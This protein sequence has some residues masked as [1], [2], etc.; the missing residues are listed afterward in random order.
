MRRDDRVRLGVRV[1]VLLTPGTA[2][3]TGP[4]LTELGTTPPPPPITPRIQPP[5]RQMLELS[6]VEALQSRIYTFPFWPHH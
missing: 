3:R 6:P 5:Q 2:G 1:A 4:G